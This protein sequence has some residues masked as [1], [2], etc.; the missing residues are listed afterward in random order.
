VE[1]ANADARVSANVDARGAAGSVVVP[2]TRRIVI[3]SGTVLKVSLIDA[4]DS[5]TNAV[6]DRF[7]THLSESIMLNGETMLEKG[8]T[9]KLR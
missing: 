7:L 8:T 6:G 1:A 5:G 4:L 9:C 2:D 3:P